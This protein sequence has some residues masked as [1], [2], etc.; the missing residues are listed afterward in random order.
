MR[1]QNKIFSFRRC[2]CSKPSGCVAFYP[3]PAKTV[4]GANQGCL[5]LH[6]E[7]RNDYLVIV[8]WLWVYYDDD[9]LQFILFSCVVGWLQPGRYSLPEKF[10]LFDFFYNDRKVLSAT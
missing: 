10:C 2:L 3:G 9:V 6:A 5:R 1:K 8:A 4:L 7:K